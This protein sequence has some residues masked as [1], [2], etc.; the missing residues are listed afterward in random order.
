MSAPDFAY[1]FQPGAEPGL[2]LLHG[3]GGD[4]RALVPLGRRLAPGAALLSPR[5][6]VNERGAARFFR[7]FAEGVLD[8]A[9]WRARALELAEF[10][11]RKRREFGL[12]RLAAVGYSN[13]A[14]IAQ[15]LLLLR[16]EVIEAAVLLR[17]MFVTDDI[18][19][20]DLAGRRALLL[21]GR[22]DPLAAAGGIERIRRQLERRGAE[23]TA[24]VLPAGH[25]LTEEDAETAAAWLRA[26][27]VSGA[28]PLAKRP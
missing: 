6:R 11:A 1:F 26:A 17:P 14:N 12:A 22:A 2:L 18:P 13:G 4:E 23:V 8:V 7:R 9:D 28:K 24:R 21:A 3:T 19:E 25:N 15:G 5:G 10:V 20:A 27:G 16:P